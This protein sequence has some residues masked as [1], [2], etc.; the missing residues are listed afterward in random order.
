MIK[1]HTKRPPN[2][3][4]NFAPK[5]SSIEQR[6]ALRDILDRLDAIARKTHTKE[7]DFRWAGLAK[8]LGVSLHTVMHWSRRGYVPEAM[9]KAL[10]QRY[11]RTVVKNEAITK[12]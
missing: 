8:D 2:T 9:A 4:E 7:I 10:E 12:P 6:C 3:F 1:K 5:V 11:G